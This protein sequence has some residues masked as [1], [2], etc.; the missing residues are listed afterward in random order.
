M[1]DVVLMT[2]VNA[3]KNLLHEDCCVFLSELAFGDDL[4]EKL[5]S[6]ANSENG[7]FLISYSVTM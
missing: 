3:P 5:S 1:D 2:V 4:I 6:L 7:Y